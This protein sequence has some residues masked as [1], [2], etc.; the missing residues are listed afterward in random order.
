MWC[1]I[2]AQLCRESYGDKFIFQFYENKINISHHF[3][4]LFLCLLQSNFF[5][6][7]LD[8]LSNTKVDMS[9][10]KL[11]TNKEIGKKPIHTS[12][13]SNSSPIALNLIKF[14]LFLLFQTFI[15]FHFFKAF[16]KAKLILM[17]IKT[18]VW[19]VSWLEKGKKKSVYFLE[20]KINK[21]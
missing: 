9:W 15:S 1:M 12:S 3:F 8:S 14:H 19:S 4:L 18:L 17:Q 13:S 21:K 11:F 20:E 2:N 5:I 16:L 6:E 10:F 7:K